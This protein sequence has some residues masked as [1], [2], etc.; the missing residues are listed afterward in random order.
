MEGLHL[1]DD[2]GNHHGIPETVATLANAS[3][4]AG[5]QAET[6]PRVPSPLHPR[7]AAKGPN[8]MAVT[9][10]QARCRRCH[11]DFFLFEIVDRRSTTCPRCGRSLSDSD[12]VFL[13]AAQ[14]AEAAL[15]MLVRSLVRIH[16]SHGV[17]GMLPGS[18]FRNLFEGI[19]WERSFRE[20]RAFASEALEDLDRYR[21]RWQADGERPDESAADD[22]NR[23]R[24]VR[25]SCTRRKRDAGKS[26]QF[27]PVVTRRAS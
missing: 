14:N 11:A 7:L 13:E 12:F 17:L 24:S 10:L 16:G 1:G 9:P 18:L 2:V 22:N 20:D 25:R 21:A 19:N 6:H 15:R 23:R 4:G 8:A 26:A 5:E 27:E 3:A